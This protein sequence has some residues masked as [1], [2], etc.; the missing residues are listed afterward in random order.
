[1]SEKTVAICQPTFLAWAGW[2]DLADQVDTLILLDD[3][4]FSRQSWQQRNR[5]RTAAGLTYITAPVRTAGRLGQRILDT[6]LADLRFIDK[7]IRTISQNYSH[8]AGFKRYFPEFCAVL[9]QSAASG[10][11]AELN[12]GL[13]AWLAAQL[14]VTTPRLRS[15]ELGVTGKRGEYVAKL[16]EKV[17]ASRYLSPA[18]AEEYLLEDRAQFDHRAIAVGL[19]EFEH[20]LYRQCFQPFMPFASVLDLLLNEGESAGSILRSGRRS[21]R[22][23]GVLQKCEAQDHGI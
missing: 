13:L 5:I 23:L 12:C 17:G 2:F 6:E 7:I 18:G 21:P 16:C 22:P 11:L 8:A 4:A 19:H 10:S 20:P 1:M 3:V 15:S 9:S 14:G